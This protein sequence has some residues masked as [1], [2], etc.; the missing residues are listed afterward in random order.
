MINMSLKVMG[1][2]YIKVEKALFA[3]T[4]GISFKQIQDFSNRKCCLPL[5]ETLKAFQEQIR[6]W[7]KK[8]PC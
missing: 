4:E 6:V 1:L 8:S 5:F 7:K 3:L 2:L